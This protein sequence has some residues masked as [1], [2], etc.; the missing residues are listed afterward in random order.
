MSQS[1]ALTVCGLRLTV[2]NVKVFA[3]LTAIINFK[4][5]FMSD[6][7]DTAQLILPTDFFRDALDPEVLPLISE[8]FHPARD[9][10]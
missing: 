2:S 10:I 9:S 3:S 6:L 7:R 5:E 8:L 4:L 1:Y